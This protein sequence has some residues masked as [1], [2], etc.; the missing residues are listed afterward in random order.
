MVRTIISTAVLALLGVASAR[1][2]L[3]LTPKESFYEVEGIRCA[4]V[5]FRN[6]PGKVTYTPPGNWTLSGGGSKLALTPLD[7]A[8]AGATIEIV[9]TPVPLPEA[10]EANVKAYSEM[11][12][13]LVPQGA[14]KIELVEALVCPMRISGKAMIEMTLAYSFYGQPFRMNVLI[15]PRGQEQLRFQFSSRTADFKTLQKDFRS[16]LFTMQGL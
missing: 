4:N 15:M 8:Q 14:S 7:K 6:G 12:A 5:A 13:T 3:D 1:A 11:A 10:T 9:P 16:S 2:Q